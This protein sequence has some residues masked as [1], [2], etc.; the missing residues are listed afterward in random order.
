MDMRTTFFV[1]LRQAEVVT[2]VDD[3]VAELIGNTDG[4]GNIHFLA[5]V[6]VIN[7]FNLGAHQEAKLYTCLQSQTARYIEVAYEGN[8]KIVKLSSSIWR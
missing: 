2:G 3:K 4:D 8:V 7:I 1:N 5:G 6:L